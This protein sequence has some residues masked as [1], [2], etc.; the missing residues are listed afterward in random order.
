[1]PVLDKSDKILRDVADKEK[2]RLLSLNRYEPANE[3][4]ETNKDALSDGDER[5]KGFNNGSI[6]N[7]VDITSRINMLNKNIFSEANPYKEPQ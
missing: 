7:S 6:G 5:G 4:S 3:Y 2:K 1:M